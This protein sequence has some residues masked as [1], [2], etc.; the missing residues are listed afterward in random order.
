MKPYLKRAR[1]LV[2]E[3]DF[4]RATHTLVEGLRGSP[5]DD[6]ALDLLLDAFVAEEHRGGIEREIVEILA[7][8]PDGAERMRWIRHRITDSSDRRMRELIRHAERTQ[9]SHL[10]HDERGEAVA[11]SS[12]SSKSAVVGASPDG[13]SPHTDEPSVPSRRTVERSSEESF[14]DAGG[15][16]SRTAHEDWSGFAHPMARRT[17]SSDAMPLAFEPEPVERF[18]VRADSA[19]SND[20]SSRGLDEE[21]DLDDGA[22]SHDVSAGSDRWILGALAVLAALVLLVT[23]FLATGERAQ[24]TV[25]DDGGWEATLGEEAERPDEEEIND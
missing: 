14:T 17:E 21:L 7:R 16:R 10:L 24:Q 3:G 23:L 19:P 1:A 11:S 15:E 20:L 25:S 13:V 9:V 4:A 5:E 8:R 18:D 22:G 2:D 6:E 12:S